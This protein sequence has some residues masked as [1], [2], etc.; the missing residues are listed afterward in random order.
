MF[1][2]FIC[3]RLV[4]CLDFLIAFVRYHKNMVV[5][6]HHASARG[7]SSRSLAI[8]NIVIG[9]HI[10][11]FVQFL[12]CLAAMYNVEPARVVEERNARKF[13][14]HSGYITYLLVKPKRS[15]SSPLVH[16]HPL[17]LTRILNSSVCNFGDV[18][19]TTDSCTRAQIARETCIASLTW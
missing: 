3:M 10:R 18:D 12:G 7:F 8:A 13:H 1:G 6:S 19:G 9:I 2:R 14:I 17:W 16:T 11:S 5:A 4:G 15:S